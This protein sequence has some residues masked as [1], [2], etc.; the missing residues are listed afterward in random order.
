MFAKMYLQNVNSKIVSL[1]FTSLQ[2]VA[3][4]LGLLSKLKQLQL[5]HHVNVIKSGQ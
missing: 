5:L 3:H 2:N 4:E 1:Q